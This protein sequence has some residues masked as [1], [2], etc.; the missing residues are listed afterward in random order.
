MSFAR[1]SSARRLRPCVISMNGLQDSASELT[2]LD[3]SACTSNSMVATTPI[4]ARMDTSATQRRALAALFATCAVALVVLLAAHPSGHP[5]TFA[6][7]IDLEIS[8]QQIGHLVHGGAIVVLTLLLSAHV[9]FARTTTRS[10]LAATTAVVLFGA[11]SMLLTG[12]LVIDGFVVPALAH[13]FQVAKDTPSQSGVQS[14]IQF[15]GTIIGV[16]MPMSLA[17]FGASAIA[18]ARP[19]MSLG[20][21]A[22]FAGPV[23]GAIGLGTVLL[24]GTSPSSARE[25]ALLGGLVL[26]AVW[27]FGFVLAL[28]QSSPSNRSQP[29]PD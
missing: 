17:A 28:S 26:L 13:L 11:A 19:L 12:S 23:V 25:H 8:T 15:A 24:I 9:A 18:Y 14:Q 22:R 10:T 16:L 6:E 3:K 20:G 7:F 21:H 27:Q 5:R 4:V 1:V 29:G 2:D